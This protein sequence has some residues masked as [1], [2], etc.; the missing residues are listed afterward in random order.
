MGNSELPGVN[1]SVKKLVALCMMRGFAVMST[2][3]LFQIQDI[4]KHAGA[5]ERW[6]GQYRRSKTGDVC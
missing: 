5:W 1:R 6:R 4:H 3:T 2:G